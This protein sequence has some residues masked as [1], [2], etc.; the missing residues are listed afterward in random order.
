MDAQWL[1]AQFSHHRDKSKAALA[2]A[3]GL[4][5]PAVSKI[6]SG[7]RQIKATEYIKMR[8][9]FGLPSGEKRDHEGQTQ[10]YVVDQLKSNHNLSDSANE[11]ENSQSQ[12]ILPANIIQKHTQ[13]TSDVIKSFRV[14]DHMMAP[15]FKRDEHVLVDLSDKNPTPPGTF[16]VSDGFGHMLR[17]CE[18][19]PNSNPVKIKITAHTQTYQPQ[20]LRRE[21][22]EILGRVI[23]KLQWL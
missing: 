3:L 2:Q 16:I 17:N 12:W 23:A 5:P 10:S 21:E 6:L 19:V 8:E 15:D 7:V 11:V 9:F 18:Y 4:E 13:S 20:I 22:F 1:H 14:G